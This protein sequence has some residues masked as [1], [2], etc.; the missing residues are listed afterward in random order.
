[1]I[2]NVI[3]QRFMAVGFLAAA[4]LLALLVDRAHE[5]VRRRR[6]GWSPLAAVAAGLAVAAVALVPVLTTFVP[7]MP[8]AMRPV[9]LPRWYTTVA[10]R[11]PPGR[12]LLSYPEPFSGIQ[13]AMAWQAVDRMAYSQAGGGGPQGV[14]AR[15]GSARAG[16][17]VLGPLAFGVLV[18]PPVGTRAQLAAVRH[19]LVVW[20]VNTV[21]I[22]TNPAAPL[23]QQGHDPVYAAGFMTEALGRL[24]VLEA[25]AWVWNDVSVGRT[26]AL[27]NAPAVLA[28]CAALAER[29]ERHQ[30]ATLL[31]ANCVGLAA[32][33]HG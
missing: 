9:I 28:R 33:H 29:R 27:A 22:A 18:A 3:E 15:A 7:S 5:A 26:P 8:F 12:V 6:P 24:P 31:V 4:V 1:V 25:G 30:V 20:R 19:A 16:F 17:E 23:L 13:V 14:S 11:L 21:V 2:D 10:P 32:L